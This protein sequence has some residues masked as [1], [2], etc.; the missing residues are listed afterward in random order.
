METRTVQYIPCSAKALEGLRRIATDRDC[1]L[2]EAVEWVS[3]YDDDYIRRVLANSLHKAL[4][5]LGV[6]PKNH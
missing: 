2:A 4:I 3:V 5:R 1:T 6:D